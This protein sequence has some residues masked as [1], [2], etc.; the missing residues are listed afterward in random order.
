[1]RLRMAR[2]RV[3]RAGTADRAARSAP[4]APSMTAR[5]T[6]C[7]SASSRRLRSS[8]RRDSSAE[9]SRRKSLS[10]APPACLCRSAAS[11]A[12][13]PGTRSPSRY[14]P[15]LALGI[16]PAA[17]RALIWRSVTPS[18]AEASP[19]VMRAS[20]AVMVAPVRK[21]NRDSRRPDHAR[22]LR[23]L[24]PAR[25]DPPGKDPRPG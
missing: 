11:V 4:P 22:F 23:S 24:G 16:L 5:A 10:A 25:A 17:A 13:Y 3:T 20:S 15:R 12:R 9:R 19:A 2:S 18:N 8:T 7:A 6:A 14:R 21:R 1:M